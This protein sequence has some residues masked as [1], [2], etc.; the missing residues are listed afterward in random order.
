MWRGAVDAE[1]LPHGRGTLT[2]GKRARF[3]GR[4]THGSRD[5][6]GCL[7]VDEGASDSE[8]GDDEPALSTLRVR[9]RRDAPWG[10]GVFT[11]PDGATVHGVW[12]DGE[13][14]GAAH[15]RHADGS[16]RRR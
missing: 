8:D 3:E 6:V 16:E 4:M 15:E 10:A 13:L 7:I 5:G 14:R 1:G 2:L 9:W 12:E 11:E